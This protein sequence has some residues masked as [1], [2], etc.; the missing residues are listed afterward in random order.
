ME[1]EIIN[2]SNLIEM[3]DNILKTI[4]IFK[5]NIDTLDKIVKLNILSKEDIDEIKKIIKDCDDWYKSEF[6]L[7]INFEDESTSQY[8]NFINNKLLEFNDEY[9]ISN[10]YQ[11]CLNEFFKKS[12]N[13]KNIIYS[14]K[15]YNLD[16][17][18]YEIDVF[19]E[20]IQGYINKIMEFKNNLELINKFKT[21][22]IL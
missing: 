6:D 19:P 10:Y 21:I 13:S 9:L 18:K 7:N 4:N 1:Q 15:D 14:I 8:I 3:K 17:L 20:T 11:Q 22:S 16:K 2:I 12:K 5:D